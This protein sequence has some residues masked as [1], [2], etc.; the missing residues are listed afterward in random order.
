[1]RT[2][3][4]L[5]PDVAQKLKNRMTEQRAPLKTV[6]NDALRRGLAAKPEPKPREP[7]RVVPHSFGFKP[8]IDVNKLNQLLDELDAQEF[9]AKLQV[10]RKRR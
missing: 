7:F 9:A 4:T 10:R 5:D 1:M 8:G 6:I 2:T 3:L